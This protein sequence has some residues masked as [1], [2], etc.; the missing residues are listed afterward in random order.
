LKK[1]KYLLVAAAGMIMTVMLSAPVLASGLDPGTAEATPSGDAVQTGIPYPTDIQLMEQG[2]RNYLHKTFT[3]A[4][5]YNPDSLVEPVF[6]QGGYKYRFSEIIQRDS[7]P[8]SD[9]KTVTESKTVDSETDDQATIIEL[10]GDKLPYSDDDGYEGELF[11]LPDS[12]V[13][14]ETGQTSYSYNVTDTREFED[15]TSNDMATIPK[16]VVKGGVTLPLKSVDWQVTSEE[17]MGY[18]EVPTEYTAIAHYSAPATGTKASGYTAI[19]T[20]SGEVMR[21]LVG[22]STYTIVYEGEQIIIPFNFIPFIITGVIV[23]GCLI[24]CVILWRLRKNVEV[25][26]YQSGVPELHAKLRVSLKKPIIELRQLSD[27]E[28]RLMF[29]KHFSKRLL[30]QKIFVVSRYRNTRFDLNGARIVDLWLPGDKE[31]EETV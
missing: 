13:T 2:S 22:K 29:D 16:S 18:S 6:S 21:E 7:T 10:L 30:D 31:K 1:A 12:I 27:V 5:D 19:A 11:L 9:S 4:A 23:V 14:T 15:L 3:V 8:A 25:Y 17:S 28:V 26:V 24:A 20:Y